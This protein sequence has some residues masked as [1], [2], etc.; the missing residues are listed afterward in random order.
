MKK[1]TGDV[2]GS[3]ADI[4]KAKNDLGYYPKVSFEKG[5]KITM[6]WYL[7]KQIWKRS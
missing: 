2:H 4:S 7:E 6:R 1:R 3:L 5:I